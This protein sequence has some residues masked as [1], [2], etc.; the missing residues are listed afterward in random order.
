LA[1]DR[2]LPPA[3]LAERGRLARSYLESSDPRRQSGFGGGAD[4]WRAE[5]EP[6]LDAFERDGSLLD[7]GCANGFLVECLGARGAE[8]GLDVTPFGLD[9]SPELIALARQRLPE[10]RSNFQVRNAWSWS[11]PRRFTYVYGVADVVPLSHLGAHLSR[12]WREFLEPGGRLIVG[13][14][15]SCSRKIPPLDLGE[16]L[17]S[18]GLPVAGTASAGPGGVVCF[19]WVESAAGWG[20]Q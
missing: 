14:Y 18:Y 8:R 5:R 16:R 12:V 2:E 11:P 17:P 4:R 1:N 7:L 19:A 3:F 6:I 13:S 20:R 9:L 15:G 10:L